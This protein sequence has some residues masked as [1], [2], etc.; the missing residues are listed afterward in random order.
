MKKIFWGLFVSVACFTISSCSSDEPLADGQELNQSVSRIQYRKSV[1]DALATAD[2]M[3]AAMEGTSITRSGRSVESIEVIGDAE[4]VLTRSGESENDTIFYLVNYSDNSGFAL[5]SSD[6]RTKPVYAISDEGNLNL[7]DTIFNR[8]LALF[9]KNA[10]EDFDCYARGPV[11][12]EFDSTAHIKPD[13]GGPTL[14][15]DDDYKFETLKD[16]KPIL[17]KYP[18]RWGQSLPFNRYCP[19]TNSGDHYYVG[20]VAVALTQLLSA[21]GVPDFFEGRS[22]DW[23]AINEAPTYNYNW[24][25]KE[26]DDLAF[27]MASIG[28]SKYLDMKYED[29]G[30]GARFGK[31]HSMLCYFGLNSSGVLNYTGNIPSS[32]YPVAMGANNSKRDSGHAWILDGVYSY[33]ITSNMYENGYAYYHFE[34]CV[35]G[36]G[37]LAN[38]Y[39]S[40]SNKYGFGINPHHYGENDN[41]TTSDQTGD[42]VND[43][44]YIYIK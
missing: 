32:Y 14:P 8:G 2:K 4:K 19:T 9:I 39:Y 6:W 28:K 36:W 33:K 43:F 18:S 27:F 38:G 23:N 16:V 17:K 41:K 15:T 21:A 40:W 13:I 31:I 30:S 5:L 7:S 20:C 42:Y 35:W 12:T 1:K 37:G 25:S 24:G 11:N 44:Q 29:D 10:R 34:H 22:Y 26:M 3:F